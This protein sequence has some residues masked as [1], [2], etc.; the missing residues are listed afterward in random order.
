[1]TAAKLFHAGR[2]DFLMKGR[3]T[4]GELLKGVLTPEA[5]LRKGTLMSHVAFL[6]CP[7]TLSCFA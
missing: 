2:A 3:I 1:M 4:S 7:V 5:N 6:N